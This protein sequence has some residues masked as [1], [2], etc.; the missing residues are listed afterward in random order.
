MHFCQMI[1]R[2]QSNL[3]MGWLSEEVKSFQT[4]IKYNFTSY[5]Q[6][7]WSGIGS[8]AGEVR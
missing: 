8:V 2:L 7:M 1:L 6:C 5:Y 4:T 3:E